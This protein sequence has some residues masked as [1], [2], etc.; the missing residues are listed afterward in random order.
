LQ[1]H[2]DEV[3]IAKFSNNGKKLATVG[4]DNIVYLWSF[5]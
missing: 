2:K 5:T 4:K 3:W 1:K